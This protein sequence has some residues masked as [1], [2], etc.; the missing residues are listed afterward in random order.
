MS[1]DGRDHDPDP[2]PPGHAG[3][4]GILF[5]ILLVGGAIYLVARMRHAASLADCMFTR[6]PACRQMLDR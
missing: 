6:A 3:L 5:V 2:E 4:L 1:D